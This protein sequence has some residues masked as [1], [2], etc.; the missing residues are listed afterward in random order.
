[1]IVSENGSFLNME[2]PKQGTQMAPMVTKV[3]ASD[4]LPPSQKKVRY[5]NKLQEDRMLMPP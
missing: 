5:E 3:N 2:L 1:M 4:F